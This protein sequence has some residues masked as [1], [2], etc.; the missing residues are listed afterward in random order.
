[1]TLSANN[2]AR[3]KITQALGFNL[4]AGNH[5]SDGSPD[6]RAGCLHNHQRLASIELG[7]PDHRSKRWYESGWNPAGNRGYALPHARNSGFL[8]SPRRGCRYLHLRICQR[9]YPD[10]PDPYRHHQPGRNSISRLR[11]VRLRAVRA[12]PQIRHQH[13]LCEPDP[14]H[15]DPAG[16]HQHHRR[17]TAECA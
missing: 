13:P 2:R 8:D 6:H 11:V 10:A 9:Q 4:A 3:G 14:F 16:D 1:M 17:S 7:I 12:L 15:H 5:N